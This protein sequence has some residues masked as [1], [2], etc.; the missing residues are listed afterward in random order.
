MGDDIHIPLSEAEALRLML[1][2]TAAMPRSGAN[3][4]WAEEEAG[5]EESLKAA[6]RWLFASAAYPLMACR[7]PV[8]V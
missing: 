2:P 4:T 5:E 3:A 8:G 7:Q 1:K 6:T